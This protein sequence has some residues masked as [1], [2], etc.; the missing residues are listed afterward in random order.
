MKITNTKNLSATS[1]LKMV[2]YGTSGTGKTTLAKTIGE[3]TLLISAESGLLTLSGSDI[4]VIDISQDDN[5]NVIPKEK[6]IA[7]L[8]EVYQFLLSDEAKKK[9]RWIFI[10]SL[11][12]ISQ[13][14]VECLQAEFPDRKDSLVLYGENSKRLRSL[15]KSFRDLPHYN[16]VMTALSVIDKDEAGMRFTTI[17]LVGNFASKLPGFFDEVFFM[18]VDKDGKRFLVTETS[19]RMVAK[20]RSGKLERLEV[21]DLSV[22]AKKIRQSTSSEKQQKQEKK[23]G[24]K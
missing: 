3:S 6:R 11:T 15:V 5:G 24:N 17:D 9:Y 7:R 19:E 2:I 20:D 21:P 16:V 8:G 10:D 1:S 22:I 12:E 18:G 13:N 4:D 23:E 14:L